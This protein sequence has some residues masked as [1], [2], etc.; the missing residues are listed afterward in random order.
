MMST[1]SGVSWAS[2]VI[3]SQMESSGGSEITENRD[4]PSLRRGRIFL[5]MLLALFTAAGTVA[6]RAATATHLRA[7]FLHPLDPIRSSE[8]LGSVL[9]TA[10]AG[11]SVTLFIAS[12]LLHVITMRRAL[13]AAALLLIAGMALVAGAS[14]LAHGRAIFY[15]LSCATLL[16]GIGWGLVEAAINPLTSALYAEDKTHRLNVLHAWF[17]GGIVAGSLLGLGVDALGIDWRWSA[18]PLAVS[19]AV[20]LLLALREPFPA[21]DQVTQGASMREMIGALVQQPTIFLWFLIMTMTATTEFA[22]GQWVDFALSAIVGMRGILLLVYVS[23]LM[24]VMRHFA[25]PLVRRLSNVGLLLVCAMSGTAGLLGLSVAD[26]PVAAFAA[27]TAWGMGI[28]FFWP[29]MLA[30]VAERYPRGGTVVYGLMGSAGAAATYLILPQIGRIYDHA[31]VIAAGG[32]EA[33]A[34]LSGAALNGPLAAAASAS[35]QAVAFIPAALVLIFAAIAIRD[36]RRHRGE[37]ERP[38]S[39][40][41]ILE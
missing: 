19:A 33:L 9:G 36:R 37:D 12:P 32:P 5:I 4:S 38:L 11:F 25:G 28:C 8:L 22:P 3:S 14:V 31:K 35:F 7:D 13:M 40:E 23:A 34:R 10:F 18:L 6:L 16:Q 2:R 29:T 41:P 21:A 27:A 15:L 20:M 24:F 17:P 26:G 39:N 30:T 1:E